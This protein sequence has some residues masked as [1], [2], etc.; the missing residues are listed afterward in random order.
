MATK[1]DKLPA[2]VRKTS[3]WPYQEMPENLTPPRRPSGWVLAISIEPETNGLVTYYPAGSGSQVLHIDNDT[4]HGKRITMKP[5]YRVHTKEEAEKF[6]V[7]F[8]SLGY[9]RNEK[10]LPHQNGEFWGFNW[11][12]LTM[13]TVAVASQV[14]DNF[15]NDRYREAWNI[16]KAFGEKLRVAENARYA[17]SSA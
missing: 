5:F 2:G 11:S 10:M 13:A 4:F 17:S 16:G 6:A 3:A 15:F 7:T 9:G 1:I 14:A 8:C 12:S